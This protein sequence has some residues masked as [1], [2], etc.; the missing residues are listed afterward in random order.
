MFEI[1]QAPATTTS[2]GIKLFIAGGIRNCPPWQNELIEKLQKDERIK[3]EIDEDED[4]KIIILNPRCKE[5]PDEKSQTKWEYDNLKKS[6]IIS[7]WFSEGSQN[8]IT[9]FEYGSHLHNH[10]PLVVGCHPNY[11]KRN[12]VI[13]QTEL[14]KHEI[15]V[16]QNFDEFYEDLV[17]T[18][19]GHIT[20]YR[21]RNLNKSMFNNK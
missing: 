7:F 13:L 11:E 15:K 1:V 10:I 8:P 2:K 14:A 18:L 20:Q 9:L 6:D 17:D 3:E 5:V 21:I 19:I 12:N 4:I 16:N